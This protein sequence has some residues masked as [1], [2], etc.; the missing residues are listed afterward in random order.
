MG[1]HYITYDDCSSGQKTFIDITLMNRINNNLG[2]NIFSVCVMDE[3]TADL[4]EK[5]LSYVTIY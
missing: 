2:S 4:D 3:Y 1:N 5:N